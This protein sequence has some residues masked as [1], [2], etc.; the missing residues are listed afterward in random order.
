METTWALIVLMVGLTPPTGM[1]QYGHATKE[2]CLLEASHYCGRAGDR[3]F[4]CKCERGLR[5]PGM[6]KPMDEQ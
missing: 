2:E 6:I 1:I 3:G 4:R 5:P